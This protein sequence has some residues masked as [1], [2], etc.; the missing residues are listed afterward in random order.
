MGHDAE[1]DL[2]SNVGYA[3]GLTVVKLYGGASVNGT[4]EWKKGISSWLWYLPA[5]EH[6]K[7]RVRIN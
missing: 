3:W 2:L 6:A 4:L 1:L 7:Q 5:Y